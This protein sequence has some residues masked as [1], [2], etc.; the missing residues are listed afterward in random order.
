[1][2]TIRVVV[3]DAGPLITLAKLG[4]LDALLAFKDNV[5]IVVTD[6]VAFETTRRKGDFPDAQAIHAFLRDNAGRVEIEQT[7]GGANYMQLVK[8]QEELA[9]NPA[10][11]AQLGVSLTPPSDPGEMTIVEYVRALVGKPPGT[12][13]LIL[14][15]DDY[16]LRDVAPLPGNAHV[17]STRAFLNIL[18]HIADLPLKPKLWDAVKRFRSDHDA[19]ATVDRTAAK[20]ATTWTDALEPSRATE[21]VRAVRRQRP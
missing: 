8:L 6:Y 14:A 1:M 5:R 10:L 2:S 17:I 9:S 13:A 20:I 18:P 12:P 3:P 11:A 15:E 16:L 21:V 4:A 7:I 19:A